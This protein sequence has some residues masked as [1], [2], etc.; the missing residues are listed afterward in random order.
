MN[1]TGGAETAI[2]DGCDPRVSADGRTLA[3]MQDNDHV[4]PYPVMWMHPGETP[5][6]LGAGWLCDISRDGRK[7]LYFK[8]L[9]DENTDPAL[10]ALHAGRYAIFSLDT[11]KEVLGDDF[12][13]YD[14]DC[15]EARFSPDGKESGF[16]GA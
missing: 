16:V 5:H 10:A 7:I 14:A 9:P 1:I 3:Y 13:F 2:A 8:Y 6:T 4:G 12:L 11:M 15:V